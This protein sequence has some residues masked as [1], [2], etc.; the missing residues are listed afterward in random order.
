[1]HPRR[2]YEPA[3]WLRASEEKKKWHRD[4]CCNFSSAAV[5]A[6]IQMFALGTNAGSGGMFYEFRRTATIRLFRSY[7]ERG[8][9]SKIFKDLVYDRRAKSNAPAMAPPAN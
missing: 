2:Y 9:S 1:M 8:L 4:R 3:G 7:I 6:L 5:R